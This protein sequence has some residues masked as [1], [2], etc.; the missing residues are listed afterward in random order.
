MDLLR[1]LQSEIEQRGLTGAGKADTLALRSRFRYKWIPTARQAVADV[2]SKP[3][4][5]QHAVAGLLPKRI[6]KRA[7]KSGKLGPQNGDSNEINMI[8]KT[9]NQKVGGSIPPR[10]TSITSKT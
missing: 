4:E 2:L 7:E 8:E 5:M 9:L 1:D 6:R 10:P 3:T